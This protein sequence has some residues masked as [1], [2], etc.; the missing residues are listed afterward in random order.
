MARIRVFL[1]A[2]LAF[3]FSSGVRAEAPAEAGTQ[4][5]PTAKSSDSS[6]ETIQNLWKASVHLEEAGA[7]ELA[8]QVRSEAS[9]LLSAEI[10]RLEAERK[11]LVDLSREMEPAQLQISATIATIDDFDASRLEHLVE[12]CGGRRTDSA[13]ADGKGVS[14]AG[15]LGDSSDTNEFLRSIDGTV[16]SR[17]KVAAIDGQ[18]AEITIGN[19]MLQTTGVRMENGQA[20]PVVV[21]TDVGLSI[22]IMPT[23]ISD[24][25]TRLELVMFE[26]S[27]S[28]DETTIF[29]D[30]K[31]ATTI[32]APVFKTTRSQA[33]VDATNG[34]AYLL[35]LPSQPAMKDSAKNPATLLMLTSSKTEAH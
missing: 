14:F 22:S 8:L 27:V 30:P 5:R 25:E 32:T 11:K 4:S 20:T 28:G 15:F 10:D 2:A 24:H 3:G 35:A 6:L 16:V 9:K 7:S 13:V 34:S 29:E 12:Q 31:T 21:D 1:A 33:V 26:R 17:P 23:I 18:P 19:V